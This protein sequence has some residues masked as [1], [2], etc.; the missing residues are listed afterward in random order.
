M[1]GG[2]TSGMIHDAVPTR[3]AVDLQGGELGVDVLDLLVDRVEVVPPTVWRRLVKHLPG[4]YTTR[5]QPGEPLISRV[6][7]SVSMSLLF[8]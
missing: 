1:S 2:T 5:F 4:C 6:V 7:S 3:G 8:L